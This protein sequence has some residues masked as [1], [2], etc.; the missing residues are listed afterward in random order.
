MPYSLPLITA[1]SKNVHGKTLSPRLNVHS[2][3]YKQKC[4][5][6]LREYDFIEIY[7]T[8][9]ISLLGQPFN[10]KSGITIPTNYMI[11]Q[12]LSKILAVDL[13]LWMLKYLQCFNKNS[14]CVKLLSTLVLD[15]S[16][17]TL[18]LP[19]CFRSFLLVTSGII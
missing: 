16:W 12:N 15:C 1:I 2:R 3:Y 8:D 6:P 9:H 13:I 11:W 7:L 10:L 17:T 4:K 19:L 5:C 18:L 14:Y